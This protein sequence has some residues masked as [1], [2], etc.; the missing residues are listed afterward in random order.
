[1]EGKKTATNC[2]ESEIFWRKF[3]PSTFPELGVSKGGNP[4]G[5]FA[6][7]GCEL[8]ASC[9]R[10]TYLAPRPT[11]GTRIGRGA[12]DTILVGICI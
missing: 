4:L 8:V 11:T 6:A 5:D 2:G 10:T 3:Q 9:N 12:Q 1:M 7:I